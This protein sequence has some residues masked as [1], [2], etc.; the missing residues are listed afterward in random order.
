MEPLCC[1]KP[2]TKGYITTFRSLKKNV[3]FHK[4]EK[5]YTVT[6]SFSIAKESAW[7]CSQQW[8]ISKILDS[9]RL[10]NSCYIKTMAEILLTQQHANKMHI[11]SVTNS[12]GTD[13]LEP[14]FNKQMIKYKKVIYDIINWQNKRVKDLI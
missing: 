11:S 10:L 4:I 2:M 5:C 9:L 12:Q 1:I 13:I 8:C 3:A 7:M 6:S 14:H